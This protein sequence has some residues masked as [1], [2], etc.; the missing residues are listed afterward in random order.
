MTGRRVSQFLEARELL[1]PD[2]E[3]RRDTHEVRLKEELAALPET[4]AEE[5]AVWI[6]VVR[7]EGKWEH[8]GRTYRSIFRYFHVFKPILQGWLADGVE[9]LREISRDDVKDA[10]ATR[11][12]TPA[13]TIH[14]V[15]R[16]VFRALRQERVIF[17]DPTRGLIFAGIQKP[18]L[19]YPRTGWRGSSA[20]RRTT[21]S[22]S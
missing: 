2:P 22:A 8:S 16:N 14:I 19:P 17:K 20:T 11:K 18:P 9:S 5:V 7:G 1:V 6:K 21:S 12:G 15:L 3:F 4:I 10:I 13:R